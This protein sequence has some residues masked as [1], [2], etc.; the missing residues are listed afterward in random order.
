MKIIIILLLFFPSLLLAQRI[1]VDS[2]ESNGYHVRIYKPLPK[3]KVQTVIRY[4]HD[5]IYIPA[6][7]ILILRD[8]ILRERIYDHSCEVIRQETQ[9]VAEGNQQLHI[10]LI[11]NANTNG[12]GMHLGAMLA[13]GERLSFFI[14]GGMGYNSVTKLTHLDLAGQLVIKVW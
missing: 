4:E 9:S 12:Y 11:G 8:T 10:L 2:L 14:G 6:V 5:T 7:R 13:L 3:P 1:S